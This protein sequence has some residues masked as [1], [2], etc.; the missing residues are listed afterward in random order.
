MTSAQ[1]VLE[2]RRSRK[3]RNGLRALGFLLILPLLM[4]GRGA[5]ALAQSAGPVFALSGRL[6]SAD[7]P[8]DAV[9]VESDGARAGL[10][11][12]TAALATEI[13]TMV[14]GGA[15]VAV[16]GIRQPLQ[17]DN[18][19]LIRVSRIA[20]LPAAPSTVALPTAPPTPRTP[21]ATR[22]A[23]QPNAQPGLSTP[24]PTLV[25]LPAIGQP[26]AD[27]TAYAVNVRAG[28]GDDFAP[29]ATVRQGA[30]C[31]VL[32]R[33]V[34]P[35]WYYLQCPG[36]TGWVR[37]G[38]YATDGALDALPLLVPVTPTPD[39]MAT[40]RSS[41]WRIEGFANRSLAGDPA[42]TFGADD[43]NFN[44]GVDA[45]DQG[46]PVDDF[47]LRLE[48]LVPLA[49]GVYSIALTYD[50]GAR[51][52]VNEELVIDDWAEGAAR[53]QSWVGTLA[54]DMPLR[55]E[56]FEA[57]GEGLLQLAIT[58]LQ[59]QAAPPTP[60]P[61]VERLET[62]PVGQGWLATYYGSPTPGGI[63]ALA[64]I[65]ALDTAWPLNREYSIE[66][67]APGVIL[68][69]NWSA[70][71]RG[72]FVFEAG[73]Y[74]FVARGNEGV[75]VYIDGVRV[76]NAWPNA[77]DEVSNIVRDI[78]AGTHEIAVEMYDAGGLAWVRA[79]WERRAPAP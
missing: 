37:A 51:L 58:P 1:G 57:Y 49:S 61:A 54:G 23:T 65:E 59:P 38:L 78:R 30:R 56:Y 5:P 76:I 63:P 10:V 55:I 46:L 75:R 19:P 68:P 69:D 11:G 34:G 33:A 44:W 8:L 43:V 79:A 48:G 67:A 45:P 6:E 22:P 16:W 7:A 47:S 36:A 17:G 3:M 72:R 73:D 31:L 35:G 62:P 13:R 18:L 52:F 50:D 70:R 77:G 25:S 2:E 21:R 9:L 64:Q 60:S 26:I 20:E 40:P 24:Y 66:S 39:P 32:G 29:I 15:A 41:L 42:I 27:I 14:T 53:M 4:P 74:R 71:W 12:A 28:P